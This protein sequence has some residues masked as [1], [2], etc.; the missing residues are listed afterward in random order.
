MLPY[1]YK[2]LY[3]DNDCYALTVFAC[4]A[5]FQMMLKVHVVCFHIQHVKL[6]LCLPLSPLVE[7][8]VIP[9]DLCMNMLTTF[10][11]ATPYFVAIA[12]A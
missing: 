7:S 6:L 9:L 2:C 3:F 12:M 8:Y 11:P 1:V 10:T 5:C 4:L